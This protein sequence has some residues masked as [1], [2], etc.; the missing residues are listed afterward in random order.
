LR[1][2]IATFFR[3]REIRLN[4]LENLTLSACAVTTNNQ[5]LLKDFSWGVLP[6]KGLDFYPAL[7][8]PVSRI[9]YYIRDIIYTWRS[10]S[11]PA[12]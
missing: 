5:R 3:K 9:V 10:T 11:Y 6:Q 8:L 4:H 12:W 2:L 1:N 7:D